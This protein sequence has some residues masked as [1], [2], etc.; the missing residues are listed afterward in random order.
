[1]DFNKYALL[2]K[3]ELLENV[4]PFWLDNSIDEKYGG[5]FTCLNRDGSIYDTD[6]FI[7]LQARQ[8]WMFAKLYNE[9]DKRKEW[10]ECA[11]HGAEFLQK[12][13][14]RDSFN[15]YFSLNQKGEP[16]IEPYNIF[17]YA[18]ACIAFGQLYKATGIYEYANIACETFDLICSKMD[19]PK[20]KWSK[21]VAGTRELKSFSLPMI[22]SNLVLEIEP[23]IEPGTVKKTI[24]YCVHEIMNEFYNPELGVLLE[25]IK[26][27]GAFSDSFDGRLINPGHGIEAMWFMMDIGIQFNQPELIRKATA[28]ALQTVEYG[29][30]KKYS[31]LFYFM[32]CKKYPLQQLEWD[33]KLWWVHI[34]TLIAM[35]KGYELTNDERLLDW[36]LKIHDYTWSHFKDQEYGEWFGYLNRRGEVLLPLKG[37]KW[38]G[39]FHVPRGLFQCWK[40]LEKCSLSQSE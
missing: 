22:L 12:Y 11:M 1:M 28:I 36:F 18:F 26:K 30:D 24:D 5:Y 13:G 39:C 14:Y 25:N 21:Q 4:L 29:W 2:Y 32:D 20:G 6:K 37:G 40:I 9:V 34:E 19:N 10:L 16:L 7:W 8:V 27:D 35:I 31:G 23:L 33:Q 38:K 15:W 3:N 17:S